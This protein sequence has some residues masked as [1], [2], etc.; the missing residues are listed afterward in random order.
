MLLAF[1]FIAACAGVSSF[2]ACF[3][4]NSSS[5]RRKSN[6]D[7]S[8]KFSVSSRRRLKLL[9]LRI[10][11]LFALPPPLPSPLLPLSF[12]CLL[13]LFLLLSPAAVVGINVIDIVIAIDCQRVW[14]E[15]ER[16]CKLL[17]T[18]SCHL[19]VLLSFCIFIYLVPKDVINSS[20]SR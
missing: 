18:V 4:D 12:L 20:S 10:L 11:L 19:T 14:G 5:R 1:C 2:A 13:A 9:Q 15:G 6:N 16:C 8:I 17:C 7:N 3:D